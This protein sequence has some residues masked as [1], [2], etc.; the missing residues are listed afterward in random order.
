A[1][2]L[3]R[4][5]WVVTD[6]NRYPDLIRQRLQLHLP[7]SP[8]TAVLPPASAQISRRS[9]APYR[10]R[11]S[12]RHHR[13]M[14]STANSAVSCEIPTFTTARSCSTSYVPYGIVLPSAC[15]GKSCTF[16]S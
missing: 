16:T 4:A 12:M 10:R 7:G 1:I 8:A 9:A 3:A 14:L 6:R 2:P 13:R 15:E 5:W 11:P